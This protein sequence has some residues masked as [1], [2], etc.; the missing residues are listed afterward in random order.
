MFKYLDSKIGTPTTEGSLSFSLISEI[1]LF[2][3]VFAVI[4]RE[5]N[6]VCDCWLSEDD[7][8]NNGWDNNNNMRKL[9]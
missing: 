6:T 5:S 9:K 4:L 8:G 2:G 7:S 3:D 1:A